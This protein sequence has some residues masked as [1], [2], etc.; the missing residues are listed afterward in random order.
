M[1]NRW[2]KT[3]QEGRGYD[4]VIRGHNHKNVGEFDVIGVKFTF[5]R[6]EL[7][8]WIE[9]IE[10]KVCKPDHEVSTVNEI[11]TQTRK[12][13]KIG[14][15]NRLLTISNSMR[16]LAHPRL[17][18]CLG[19]YYAEL[20]NQNVMPVSRQLQE[21]TPVFSFDYGCRRAILD[22]VHQVY[23]T[24]KNIGLPC[25]FAKCS[26]KECRRFQ[27]WQAVIPP[28]DFGNEIE[29]SFFCPLARRRATKMVIASEEVRFRGATY[30]G[31]KSGT[32][33]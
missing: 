4:I 31:R 27:G 29:H 26:Y 11:V 17:Q 22:V 1:T 21:G 8:P 7:N 33:I 12:R 19:R 24:A 16:V 23:D 14:A 9:C 30:T 2:L 5:V 10:T 6:F 3:L 28:P 18:R 20:P 13:M 32:P 15:F 25:F